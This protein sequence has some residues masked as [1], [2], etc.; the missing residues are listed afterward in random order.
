MECTI[1]A[2]VLVGI[3][4]L[5]ISLAWLVFC[6]WVLVSFIKWLFNK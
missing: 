2:V 1:L 5:A 6:W 4:M 3:T